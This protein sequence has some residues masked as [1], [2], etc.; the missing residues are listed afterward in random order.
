MTKKPLRCIIELQLTT[1]KHDVGV[2]TWRIIVSLRRAVKKGVRLLD[3]VIFGRIYGIE[4]RI[5]HKIYIGQ[6]VRDFS[7]RLAEHERCKESL[8]GRA[9]RKHGKE[10]FVAVVLEECGSREALDEAEKRW[11]RKMNCRHPNGYNLTDGGGG[12][13][14]CQPSE[15]VRFKMSA[16]KLGKKLGP[17]SAA[18]R[19]K[20]R[21]SLL[22]HTVSEQ[23]RLKVSAAN[24]G[25]TH[26]HEVRVSI[27]KT[28]RKVVYPNFDRKLTEKNLTYKELARL[29]D[30]PKSTIS[31][32]LSGNLRLDAETALAI[33]EFLQTDL[34]IEELFKR[35]D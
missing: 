35:K 18:W 14:G 21:Q 32:K 10:N 17:H 30:I 1:M 28:S 26:S 9:I 31:M 23:A 12:G 15:S 19:E 22:G 4:C 20:I 7:I 13:S 3:K 27:S 2:L 16:A 5:D 11:I 8:I 25:N 29:L 6:T 24:K 33:K 34:S